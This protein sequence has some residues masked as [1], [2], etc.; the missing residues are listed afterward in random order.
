MLGSHSPLFL[1]APIP[2]DLSGLHTGTRLGLFIRLT[3]DLK[4]LLHPKETTDLDQDRT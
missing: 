3:A 2:S 1:P 4:S